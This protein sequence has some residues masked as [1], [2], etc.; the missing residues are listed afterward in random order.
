MCTVCMQVPTE[1]G[2]GSLGTGVTGICE[3]SDVG[4]GTKPRL[5]ARAVSAPDD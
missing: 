4:A 1:E 2:I 3:V 5:F